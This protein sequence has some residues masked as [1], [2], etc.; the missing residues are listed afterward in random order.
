[1]LWLNRKIKRLNHTLFIRLDYIFVL[2]KTA[3]SLSIYL[4]AI[5]QALM[6][7]RGLIED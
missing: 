6:A 7:V 5:C 3:C 2:Q 4:Q 1:M